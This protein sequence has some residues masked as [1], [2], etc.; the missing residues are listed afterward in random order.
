M[1]SELT[2][3]AKRL[4][5]SFL[6]RDWSA[7]ATLEK[8]AVHEPQQAIPLPP[9]INLGLTPARQS[10]AN[11]WGRMAALCQAATTVQGGKARS[12]RE[13][14][15]SVSTR[16]TEDQPSSLD[17]LNPWVSRTSGED[18]NHVPHAQAKLTSF[19]GPARV[20]AARSDE[21][22]AMLAMELFRLQFVH[23]PVY[24]R[25]CEAAGMSPDT[26]SRWQEIPAIPTAAFKDYAVT[27]LPPAERTHVFHSSG[28][29]AQ[30]PS[31]HFHCAESLAL[32]EASLWPW[33]ARHVLPERSPSVSSPQWALL[34]PPPKQ[35]PH[36]S[37]VHMLE[38]VRRRGRA[39]ESAFLGVADDAGGWALDL[40]ATLAA[41][42]RASET[43]SP[44]VLLGTAFAFV[45]LLDALADRKLRFTLPPG[46]RVMETGGYKGRSRSLPKAE[47]HGLI[48]ERLGIPPSRIVCEYGMSE[49]SSQA[50]DWAL[51]GLQLA[52]SP[53]ANDSPPLPCLPRYFHF[54]PWARAQIISPETGREVADGETGLLRVFDLANVWSVL[55]V[56]TEDLGV[57]R[58]NGFELVGRARSAEP[59]GCSLQAV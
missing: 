51:N 37:L 36:S 56:Q 49:L 8:S 55:A 28:T 30:R 16:S 15:L 39:P 54:P 38:T 59:R 44:L 46:S 47:L 33:F 41:L 48:T 3:F 5:E 50:Y 14:L 32:Y 34:T 9:P 26:A 17:A 43:P 27:C 2:A 13:T 6:D 53:R 40:D 10:T 4:R 1:T 11:S 24:R 23:N 25:V 7:G 45:H 21:D 20:T 22:F 58:G 42:R 52:S 31:R 12:L 35:A 19:E 18:P 57:R 29:T